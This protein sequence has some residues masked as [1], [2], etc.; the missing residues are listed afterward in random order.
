MKKLLLLFITVW[1][2]SCSTLF[3]K[4]RQLSN[5][6]KKGRV[7]INGKKVRRIYSLE[8]D[9]LKIEIRLKFKKPKKY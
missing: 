8:G 1:F 5:L 4:T 7:E 2:S 6:S 3:V 9:T